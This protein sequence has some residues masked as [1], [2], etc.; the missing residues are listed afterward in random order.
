MDDFGS[1]YS[2]L[3]MLNEAE[4]NLLKI[5]MIFMRNLTNRNKVSLIPYI[6]DI[7]KALQM[8]VLVEG[9]ETQAQLEILKCYGCRYVQ[10]FL[11]SK[12]LSIRDFEKLLEK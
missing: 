8:E 5:D 4:F 10:G 2:S 7:A 9:V 1:G 11:Y 6:M 12:P 3:N